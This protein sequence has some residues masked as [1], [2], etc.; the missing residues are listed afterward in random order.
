M[1]RRRPNDIPVDGRDAS[2]GGSGRDMLHRPGLDGLRAIAVTAVVFYHADVAWLPGGFLGVDVFFVISGYLIASLLLV[3]WTRDGRVNLRGFWVRRARRLLP[4][5]AVLLLGVSGA[6]IAVAPDAASR[7]PGDVIAAGGYVSNWWQLAR[8]DSYFEAFARPPLLR[9]L[10]SLAIEEQFYIL[11]PVAFALALR[12]V[13]KRRAPLAVGAIAAGVVSS[14]WMAAS[15]SSVA[16][17]SRVYLGTDTRATP[18]LFGVALALV[19]APGRDASD[20][21]RRVSRTVFDGLSFVALGG[22]VGLMATLDDTSPALYRG[23]FFATAVVAALLT[24]VVVHPAGGLARLLAQ[25]PFQWI[26]TRSYAIYLWHWP[27]FMLS[28]PRLDTNLGGWQLLTVRVL[29]TAAFAE[30][31]WRLVEQPFRKGA[32]QRAWREWTPRRR[33]LVAL[34]AAGTAA[35]I[36]AGLFGA[37]APRPSVLLAAAVAH[38]Q[39]NSEGLPSTPIGSPATVPP[40]FAAVAAP[41]EDATVALM[42]ALPA[43]PAPRRTAGVVARRP[44]QANPAAASAPFSS[45]MRPP[46]G[47]SILAVGDSVML[48]ARDTLEEA[49]GGQIVVDAKVGRQVDE[50][51]AALQQYRDSGYLQGVSAVVVHLGTNG[52]F[53]RKQFDRM[54]EIL[55]G[56]PRVVVENVRVP[57]R[58]EAQSNDTVRD[59][60]AGHPEARLADWFT[61]SAERGMLASDGVHPTPSGARLYAHVILEQLQADPPPQE[62]AEPT[63]TTEPPPATTEPTTTTEPPPPTDPATS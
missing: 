6:A 55:A 52:P 15:W 5:L 13:G 26:G 48:A 30:T 20:D 51:L 17:T 31:S 63:T 50:G 61:P 8:G 47:G 43:V 18:L 24:A 59:G 34:G 32:A 21:F 16:D 41:A 53:A 35:V 22:L 27:V 57:R 46:P 28:R 39:A 58:W 38:D 62:A 54:M 11:F 29:V 37:P 12:L 25:R 60:A 40:T 44:A 4:A 36:A 3:E 56:V 45:P 10:W 7:L 49:S 1:G 2:G 19:W 9:H 33:R 14:L 42:P 23:G